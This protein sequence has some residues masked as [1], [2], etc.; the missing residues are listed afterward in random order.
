MEL[1]ACLN[2]AQAA[3]TIKETKVHHKNTACALQQNHW[4]NALVLE[5]EAKAAEGWDNHAFMEALV[6]AMWACLPK[7]HGAL[8]YPYRFWPAMCP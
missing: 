1:A 2:D 7:S 4:D 5:C 3:K 6:A 8:L